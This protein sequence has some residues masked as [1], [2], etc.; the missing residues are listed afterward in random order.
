MSSI[1]LRVKRIRTTYFVEAQPTDTVTQLKTKI[2]HIAGGG[3]TEKE[4]KL[5]VVATATGGVPVK[6]GTPKEYTTLD[7]NAVLEQIGFQDDS[8]LF[9]TYWLPET[10]KWEDVD[11]P[12]FEALEDD[13]SAAGGSGAGDKEKVDEKGKGRAR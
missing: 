4:L 7:D 5:S 3:R 12:P 11:V 8:E 6:E 10:S 2:A 9:V 13:A 1:Y